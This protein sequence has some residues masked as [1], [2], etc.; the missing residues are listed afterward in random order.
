MITIENIKQFDCDKINKVIQ[1]IL[2][3]FNFEKV[4]SVMKIFEWEWCLN[5]EYKIP[6]IEELKNKVKELLTDGFY[7]LINKHIDY[8]KLGT[9]GFEI[10]FFYNIDYDEY[11]SKQYVYAA[12]VK[13]VLTN[14]DV[15][16]DEINEIEQ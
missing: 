2:D 3:N 1:D 15:G 7:E 10:E 4:H 11:S 8:Y 9:G 5:G 13:F 12:D 6:S 16:T 14:Y